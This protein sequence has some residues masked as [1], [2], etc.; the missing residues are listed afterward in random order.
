MWPVK[1][2]QVISIKMHSFF[3]GQCGKIQY[4]LGMFCKRTLNIKC[5]DCSCDSE[6]SEIITMNGHMT[7][8]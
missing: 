6:V 5:E 8:H 7:S 3:M 1:H 2:A 4:I